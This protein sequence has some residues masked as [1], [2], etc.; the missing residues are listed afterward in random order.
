MTQLLGI[1]ALGFV[2]NFVTL[3]LLGPRRSLRGPRTTVAFLLANL[4]AILALTLD[5]ASDGALVIYGSIAIV[6]AFLCRAWTLPGRAAMTYLG[7]TAA[8]YLVYAAVLTFLSGLDL[9]A[10]L[11]SAALLLLELFA[12]ALVLLYA[13]EALDRLSRSRWSRRVIVAPALDP[14][15]TPFVSIHVPSYSEPPELMLETLEALSRLEYP[16]FEVLVV[17]NNTKDPALWQPVERRCTEL[18]SRFRF[19]HVD[20]LAGYKAGACNFALRHTDPRAEI[21]AIIDADYV[22]DPAF[23][24]ETVPHFRDPALAFVQTPQ[25]YREFEG[26]RYLTD[27]LHAYAYFFAVS[28]TVRNE[29]NAPIFGGTMG[30]IRRGALEDIGGWDEWCITEDAEASLRL[31]QRGYRS[32]YV[33]RTYGRGLMPFDFDSYKKQRFRWAFGGVQILR[34]HWRSLVPFLPHPESDRL[35]P[36]QRLW[37]LAAGLLWFGEPLQIGFAAFL[38]FSGLADAIAD[39]LPARPLTEA[40]LIFP[41]LFLV[42]G[43]GR[44]VWVLRTVLRLS[45]RDALGAAV[46]MFSL[47][48]VV[49]QAALAAVLR[50]DGVFLRTSKTRSRGT[51]VRAL[52]A[53]RWETA[54]AAA[55]LSAAIGALA[56]GV[57]PGALTLAGLCCW[58][59]FLYGSAFLTSLAAVRAEAV[60]TRPT[61]H[62]R[63]RDP[64]S[65]R[66]IV[67]WSTVPAAIAAVGVFIALATAANAPTISGQL[68]AAQSQQGAL[69][70]A[71]ARPT[72]RTIRPS[73]ASATPVPLPTLVAATPARATPGAAASPLPSAANTPGAASA[74]PGRSGTHTPSASLPPQASHTP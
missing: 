21:I 20:P 22:V 44:F 12:W 61:Y 56:R 59:G 71:V 52:H 6:A 40:M 13:F 8:L 69:L 17:D 50:S 38:I 42:L 5:G 30:L 27:C 26:N 47:S 36:V 68:N 70:P 41:T 63:A 39:G 4:V 46:S 55:C 23:L 33:D 9:L 74:G 43:L 35:T 45:V 32:L 49:T 11:L 34:K 1:A 37:Y 24:R 62:R 25:D 51:L 65:G 48:F 28:M 16:S 10:A 57:S 19:F 29:Y 66:R 67:R 73:A 31:L 58:Q 15:F 60:D 7:A 64:S 2:T 14:S 54:I 18:G 3:A 53:A 72:A